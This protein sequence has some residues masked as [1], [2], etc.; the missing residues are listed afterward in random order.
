MQNFFKTLLYD[1][2]LLNVNQYENIGLFFPIGMVLI[3][4][5]IVLIAAV[6]FVSLRN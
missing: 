1:Y 3:A 4:L 5:P 6:I 2:I